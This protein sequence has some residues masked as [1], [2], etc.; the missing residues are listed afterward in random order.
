MKAAQLPIEG[1]GFLCGDAIR[2]AKLI[3]TVVLGDDAQW[4]EITEIK[5]RRN[6]ISI[7]Y[8]GYGKVVSEKKA[9]AILRLMVAQ[10]EA[11]EAQDQMENL[12]IQPHSP[13]EW[14][15]AKAKKAA[16]EA[17]ITAAGKLAE[18]VKPNINY[19]PK[20]YLWMRQYV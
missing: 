8:I 3:G 12:S 20:Q 19:L 18:K 7:D 17:I 15:A 14:A 10:K 16:A 1:R 2:A 5:T 6:P 13:D 11:S 4:Y 9:L